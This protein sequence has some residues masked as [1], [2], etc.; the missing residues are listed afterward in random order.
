MVEI[1]A[2]SIDTAAVIAAV[3]DERAAATETF[4]GTTRDH[5]DGRRVTRRG[6]AIRASPQ[7]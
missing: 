2:T 6:F 4:V 1:V 3:A 7:T 5:N